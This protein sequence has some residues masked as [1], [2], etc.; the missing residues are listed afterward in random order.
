MLRLRRWLLLAAVLG[1]LGGLQLSDGGPAHHEAPG[2][3]VLS[4]EAG[5]GAASAPAEVLPSALLAGAERPAGIPAVDAGR[6]AALGAVLFGLVPRAR[7]WSSLTAA[8]VAAPRRH[9]HA[10][11]TRLRAPPRPRVA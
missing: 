8:T 3:A 5:R 4:A 9:R 2:A 1:A 11:G 10:D 6:L 7:C